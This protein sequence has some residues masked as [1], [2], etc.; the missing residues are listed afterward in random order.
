MK[1]NVIVVTGLIVLCFFITNCGGKKANPY[2]AAGTSEYAGVTGMFAGN[3]AVTAYNKDGKD[4]LEW[5]FSKATVQFDLAA[6]RVRFDFW[7]SEAYLSEK[8]LDWKATY[9]NIVVD[10]YKVTVISTWD[11]S[12]NGK[13]LDT[14]PKRGDESHQIVIKGSGE[15]FESFYNWERSKFEIGKNTGQGGGLLGMAMGAVAKKA[16]G[17]SDLFVSIVDNYS[18][19]FSNE[20]RNLFMCRKGAV[21]KENTTDCKERISLTKTD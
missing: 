18:F 14:Q 21:Y 20:G 1:K 9:P 17:T 3:W 16:T 10:E 11:I 8:M 4:L 13:I 12:E 15:N 5:P 6:N 19:E 2:M 7:A